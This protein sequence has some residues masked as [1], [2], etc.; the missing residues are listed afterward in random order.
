[1]FEN[2]W[3][4]EICLLTLFYI[5]DVICV[6]KQFWMNNTVQN[7]KDTLKNQSYTQTAWKKNTAI[8]LKF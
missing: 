2:T 1:M 3:L 7:Y 8:W 6:E 4:A 5:L